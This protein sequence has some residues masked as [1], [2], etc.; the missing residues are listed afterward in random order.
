M[1]ETAEASSCL[2]CGLPLWRPPNQADAALP[3][4]PRCG[5]CDQFVF[6]RA[7]GCGRYDGA[8]REAILQ[9]KRQPH[10][11]FRLRRLLGK[12]F[13]RLNAIEPCEALIP[14]PLHPS[15][16]AERKF[17]QA[18]VIADALGEI[19]GLRVYPSAVIRVKQTE[20]HRFGMGQRERLRSLDNAFQVRAPRLVEGRA[21]FVVDD[22]MTTAS[23]ADEIART[24]LAAGA[25]SVS[26]L[27]L[28]RAAYHLVQ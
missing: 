19:T 22:V 13:H 7:R 21:L 15:R 12:P 24:L 6:N 20:R 2:K 14:V 11:P 27:T 23:T 5:Q 28:T 26:I 16:L 25:R 9:L 17:N 4:S 1:A 3:L 18:E 8:L 10:L